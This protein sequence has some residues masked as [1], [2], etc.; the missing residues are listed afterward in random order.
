MEFSPSHETPCSPSP[1][2]D[3]TFLN[4]DGVASPTMT[5]SMWNGD[6]DDGD[7]GGDGRI[8]TVN[9]VVGN[10]ILQAWILL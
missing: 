3:P 7:D 9:A 8:L 6:D 2:H 1:G 5:T 10:R 4:D